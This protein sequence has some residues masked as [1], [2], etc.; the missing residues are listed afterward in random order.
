M[1]KHSY[2]SQ[3]L[4]VNHVNPFKPELVIVIFMHYESRIA[5]A[6]LDL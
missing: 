3:Y 5:V 4:R 2:R 1:I 6:I